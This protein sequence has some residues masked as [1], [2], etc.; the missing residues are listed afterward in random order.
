[1][2][3]YAGTPAEEYAPKEWREQ[4]MHARLVIGDATLMGADC[5]PGQYAKPTGFSVSIQLKGKTEGE[6]IFNRLA[7]GGTIQMAF[8]QTFWAAGFGCLV[9]RYG[10][11]WMVN[12]E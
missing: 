9:D 7:E 5:P 1:M 3:P 4:I 12:C 10:I 2:L 8:Q 6:R 11:P